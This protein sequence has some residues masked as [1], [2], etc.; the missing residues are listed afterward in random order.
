VR[1]LLSKY[2]LFWL[3]CSQEEK[4]SMTSP[5]FCDYLPLD[6]DLAL[7][8]D[9]CFIIFTQGGFVPSL[10]E[11]GPLVLEKIFF[12]LNT[13]FPIVAPPDTLEINLNLHYI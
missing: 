3:S 12:N 9:I 2:E 11:I 5:H 10:S 6:K 13:V 1:K 7:H 4:F 8:L